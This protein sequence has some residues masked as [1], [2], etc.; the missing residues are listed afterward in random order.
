MFNEDEFIFEE[1]DLPLLLIFDAFTKAQ[2]RRLGI[3]TDRHLGAVSGAI[4]CA[5][6]AGH[7]DKWVSY[8]RNPNHYSFERPYLGQEYT[9]RRV[10]YAVDLLLALGLIAEQRQKPHHYGWQSRFCATDRLLK[11]TRNWSF[12]NIQPT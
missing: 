6:I 7:V 4:C 9:Q 2:L 11:L 1:R 5:A 12:P 10:F 8:S 3:T